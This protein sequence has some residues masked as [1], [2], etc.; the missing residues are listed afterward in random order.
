MALPPKTTERR[1]MTNPNDHNDLGARAKQLVE[2]LVED[3]SYG[4]AGS[5]RLRERERER[6]RAERRK[7]ADTLLIDFHNCVE[8]RTNWMYPLFRFLLLIAEELWGP[9]EEIRVEE[10]VE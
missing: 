2:D 8:Q 1:A 10:D 7:R 9:S 3:H 4:P 6:R 5:P